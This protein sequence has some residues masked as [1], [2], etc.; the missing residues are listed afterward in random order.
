VASTSTSNPGPL[1]TGQLATDVSLAF[2]GLTAAQHKLY[3]SETLT[4]DITAAVTCPTCPDDVAGPLV[5]A[6]LPTSRSVRV[7][8]TATAFAT[9]INAGKAD[10]IGCRIAPLTQLPA[11]FIYQTTNP[12]T[13]ALTGSA[14]T[15]ATI[16]AGAGQ[17]F[18][19]GMT[20][21]APIA[22]TD[23]RLQFVCDN[24]GAATL[25][26]GLNT[27]LLVADPDPVPDIVALSA[28]IANDGIVRAAPAGAFAVAVSNIGAMGMIDV[29]ADTGSATL[30]VAIALCETD[31]A[32]SACLDP[33]T[34]SVT[35]SII[36]GAT[37]TFG[38][39]VARS[40]TFPFDPANNRIFVRFRDNV[41][42]VD[43][44]ATS[45]AVD[46]R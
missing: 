2:E 46:G 32:T 1:V 29:S 22:P 10:S 30:P 12:A 17:S 41:G 40:A 37:P 20:P 6:V 43:R 24:S 19:I 13:N 42:G 3:W 11:A 33:P 16:Y 7:G 5:S 28:T 21:T 23:V 34:D 8:Q 39:F 15:P 44:G 9:I 27:L 36:H 18:V 31:P 38:V 26:S 25:V 14:N 4:G 35:T 45:V